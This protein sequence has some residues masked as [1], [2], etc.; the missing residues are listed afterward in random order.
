MLNEEILS[1]RVRQ[2]RKDAKLTQ[3]ELAG[4]IGADQSTVSRVETGRDVGTILLTKIGE[5]TGKS[6]DF[7]LRPEEPIAG[8][9]FKYGAAPHTLD[10]AARK[11]LEL[12]EDYELLEQLD[13]AP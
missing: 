4:R 5:A 9:L 12:V 6:L 7:F 8:V 1:S 2:A 10:V 11:M 13:D 3:E